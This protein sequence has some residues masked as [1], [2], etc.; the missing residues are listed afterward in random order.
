MTDVF[1][2]DEGEFVT[3][4]FETEKAKEILKKDNV[5]NPLSYSLCNGS[6]LKVDFPMVAINTIRE[7]LEANDLTFEDC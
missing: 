4:G 2:K 6:I 5:L 1:L 7:F 3:I